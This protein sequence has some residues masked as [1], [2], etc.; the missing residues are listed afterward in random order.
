MILVETFLFQFLSYKEGHIEKE[1]VY[2]DSKYVLSIHKKSE[3]YIEIAPIY[4]SI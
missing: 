1:V 2:A 4:D 3:I